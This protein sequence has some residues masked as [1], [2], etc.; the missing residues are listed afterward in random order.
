[1]LG[2]KQFEVQL[3]SET[4]KLDLTYYNVQQL[5][6]EFDYNPFE[7]TGNTTVLFD[8]AKLP[9]LLACLTALPDGDAPMNVNELAERYRR[10]IPVRDVKRL[11]DGIGEL[12]KYHLEPYQGNAQEDPEKIAASDPS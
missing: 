6:Y 1:M 2:E 5:I 4:I 11:Y 8:P 9:E 12:L 10:L 3:G 7:G